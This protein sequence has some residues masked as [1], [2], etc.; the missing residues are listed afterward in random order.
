MKLSIS[1]PDEDVDVLDEYAS[2]HRLPGRSQAVQR[3]ITH[4]RASQLEEAYVEAIK[5]WE[6]SE[7]ADA[8]DATSGDGLSA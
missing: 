7:D 1:V 2:A 4:L 3:A 6:A 5:E 8:W